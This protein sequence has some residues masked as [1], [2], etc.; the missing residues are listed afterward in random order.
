MANLQPG[1]QKT[2][3][4]NLLSRD[5][6]LSEKIRQSSWWVRAGHCVDSH[7][8]AA[9]GVMLADH[10]NAV[11]AKTRKI[12][13]NRQ[14]PFLAELFGLFPLLGMDK[15]QVRE[16]LKL[17]SLLHDLGKIEDDKTKL[18]LHPVHKYLT[19][20]QHAIVS[21]FAAMDILGDEPSLSAGEKR[22]IYALIEEHD[23]SY[24]LYKEW[25]QT[26]QMPSFA[27]W[28][29]LNDK[30]SDREGVG[31]LYLLVFKLADTHG[32]RCIFDVVW[33]FNAV[34]THYFDLLGLNLPLPQASDIR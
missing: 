10:L 26:G 30:I 2:H 8:S 33:F 24:G 3:Y 25:R 32:H 21:V 29:E 14:S 6:R 23:V 18:V 16:E 22:R 12:F 15:A 31:L 4:R 11:T 1:Y 13:S 20:K 34:K 17:V 27:R 28:R 19:C 9:S 5:T 7:F